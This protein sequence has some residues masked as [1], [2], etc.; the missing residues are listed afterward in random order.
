MEELGGP[1]AFPIPNSFPQEQKN[2]QF[3]YVFLGMM[4]DGSPPPEGR[5]TSGP[6]LDGREQFTA[7]VAQPRGEVPNLGPARPGSGAQAEQTDGVAGGM[8]DRAG[9]VAQQVVGAAREVA[10]RV[11]GGPRH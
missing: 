4:R 9:S 3:S 11:T 7:Q 6:S 2:R 8:A 1:K 10:D 5:F